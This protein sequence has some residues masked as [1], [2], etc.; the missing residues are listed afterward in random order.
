L[1]PGPNAASTPGD[2][3]MQDP[4]NGMSRGGHGSAMLSKIGGKTLGVAPKI[5]PVLT[6]IPAATSVYE[7]FLYGL[8]KIYDHAVANVLRG[9]AVVNM[10]INFKTTKVN[11][12]FI[13]RFRKFS[14]P[15][16]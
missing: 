5:T 8:S 2:M 11:Q 9:K 1:Y 6:V 12:G 3:P 14:Q 16:I 13:N 10:S 15:R 4:N 7:N